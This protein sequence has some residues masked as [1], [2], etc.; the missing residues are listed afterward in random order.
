MRVVIGALGVAM[1]FL[2]VL[3]DKL[4]F[5]GDPFPRDSLSVYYYSGMREVFV[6]ILASTGFFL[7]AYK[8]TERNLDNTL[9]VVAG[10][11]AI[12]IPLFPTGRPS[13]LVSS[14]PLTSLQKLIG[15][16]WTKWI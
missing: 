3:I 2:L 4:A 9:S 1:P 16:D 7:I 12:T 14:T 15:E 6:V 11:A 10:L 8:I 13:A 5:H